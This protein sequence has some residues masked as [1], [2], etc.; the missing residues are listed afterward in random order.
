MTETY[1][2]TFLEARN[3]RAVSA[4]LVSSEAS[5]LGLQVATFSMCP[6]MVCFSYKD[7]PPVGPDSGPPEQHHFNFLAVSLDGIPQSVY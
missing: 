6:H 2:I 7:P 5:L 3:P 1:F 4:D